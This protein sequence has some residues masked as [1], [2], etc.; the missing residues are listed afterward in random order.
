MFT[1]CRQG[2]AMIEISHNMLPGLQMFTA[3]PAA[4]HYLRSSAF[5]CGFN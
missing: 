2:E 4:N 1:L 3:R 5:I